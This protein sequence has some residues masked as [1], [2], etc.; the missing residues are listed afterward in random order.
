MFCSSCGAKLPD[1]VKFCPECGAKVIAAIN[2]GAKTVKK[3]EK[4]K[5][6][7]SIEES[8]S[9]EFVTDDG[10]F[11]MKGVNRSFKTTAVVSSTSIDLL[12]QKGR[13][14]D[15]IDSRKD[16]HTVI[17]R[18]QIVSVNLQRK[19]HLGLL[20][21]ALLFLIGMITVSV[22]CILPALLILPA[23]VKKAI[24]ISTS[25]GKKVWFYCSRR[26]PHKEF[27]EMVVGK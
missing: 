5:E 19:Y 8:K 24:V 25:D 18:N 27:V 3:Q 1:T 26:D 15:T 7:Q 20:L 23:A 22:W 4:A 21:T 10:I 11:G 14:S 12:I 6:A 17:Q 16:K 13:Y 2:D 9:F